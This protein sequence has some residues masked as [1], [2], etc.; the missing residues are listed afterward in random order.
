MFGL[1]K[2]KKELS[3]LKD[4]IE[5]LEAKYKY[6]HHIGKYAEI[7]WYGKKQKHLIV[8]V[9]SRD[10]ELYYEFKLLYGLFHKDRVAIIEKKKKK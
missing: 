8:N 6:A 2:T 1:N 7:I 10:G 5:T 4:K 9:E 3:K